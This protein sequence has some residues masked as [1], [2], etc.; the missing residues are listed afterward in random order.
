MYFQQKI[1]YNSRI[2][3]VQLSKFVLK[4]HILLSLSIVIKAGLLKNIYDSYIIRGKYM[5]VLIL[6]C[7]TGE[8]HNSAAYAVKE[9]L[10]KEGAVC[11]LADPVLFKSRRAQKFVSSFYNGMIK[12]AP[13]TFGVL[14]KAGALYDATGITSPV[15]FANATYSDYLYNYIKENKFDAVIS[16]HLYGMESLTAI[17]KK[18]VYNIPFYGVLTDYTIIPFI[19]E[20][21]LDGYFIPHESLK[22]NLIKKGM[23]EH[24][25]FP[26][27]IPV[28]SGFAV[29]MSKHDAR[30]RLNIPYDKNAVLVM[31]GG[32]VGGNLFKIC[33]ELINKTDSSYIIF[34]LTGKNT[35]LKNEL[36]S[37][38]SGS[39]RLITVPFTRD[40]NIYMNA[41]DVILT[42]PGG[43]SSTEAAV[44][45][46]PIVHVNAIPGCETENAKFFEKSGMSYNAK[47]TS[48]AVKFALALM[49]DKTIS[50][51]MINKQSI[52]INKYAAEEIAKKVI[53]I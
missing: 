3:K 33:S 19:T 25:I 41:C 28:S 34:A 16:T 2:K 23:C 30:N 9:A 1:I 43:L 36:D 49:S 42:K 45:N 13:A 20:T 8:G 50:E 39:G 35:T 48:D 51:A 14:Y 37:K 17:K 26:T 46:I 10:E 6:S 11:E 31:S 7:Y 40:V 52:T 38:Y 22:Q 29:P 5:K 32:I 44:S 53:G 47:S 27:G 24:N 21:K 4:L 18:N 12:N 15:Y